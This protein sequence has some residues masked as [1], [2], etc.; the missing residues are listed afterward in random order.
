MKNTFFQG[1]FLHAK[2]IYLQNIKADLQQQIVSGQNNIK[3]NSYL[4]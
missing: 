2:I 1:K 4:Q 3:L